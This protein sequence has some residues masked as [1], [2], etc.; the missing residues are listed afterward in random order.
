[1][2]CFRKFLVANKFTDKKGGGGSIESFRRHF[3]CLKVPK[4]FVEEAFSLSLISGVEKIY[5]SNGYVTIFYR[6]LF[7]SQD[8]NIS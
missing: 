1:M 3:F 5:A 2:L 8:P 6:K 7:V 4:N